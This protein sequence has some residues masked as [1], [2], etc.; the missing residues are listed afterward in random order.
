MVI[1]KLFSVDIFNNPQ[2]FNMY[3]CKPN[4]IPICQ[5]NGIDIEDASINIRLNNQYELSFK[6]FKYIDTYDG[7]IISNG[8]SSFDVGMEILVENIGYF[9]LEYPK[10]YLT[11][12]NE[13]KIISA[14]SID[15][16][17][18]NKDLINFKINLG[19][20][21]SLEYLVEYDENETEELINEYNGSPYDY[22][23]FYNTLDIQLQDI[24]NKYTDGVITDK[25]TI[26]KI[27]DICKI[28]P[29]LKN[30]IVKNKDN[31]NVDIINYVEYVYDSQK[32]ISSIILTD[33]NARI[34]ELI[35]F[36]GK[37]KKQLS[38]LDLALEKCNCN[39]KI[40]YVDEELCNKRFQFD[41]SG[42]N[43][44]S[45]LTQELASTVECLCMFDIKTRTINIVKPD[46]LG[47]DTGILL[48]RR[49]VLN[50]LDITLNENNLCTRYNVSGGNNLN[51]NYVNFGTSRIDDISYYLY[52]RD[53]E[54]NTRKYMSD[55][56]A[57]KYIEYS[58]DRELARDVFIDLSKQYNQNIDNIYDLNYR[59]P[60]DYL[61]NNWGSYNTKDLENLLKSFKSLLCT[62]I[63]MYKEEYSDLGCNDDGSVNEDYIKTT[64]Y[65]QDYFSY[66]NIISQ[67]TYAIDSY[68]NN[69]NYEDIQ[70]EATLKEIN[71]FKTEWSLYGIV[72]LQNKLETYKNTMKAMRDSK[73][74]YLKEDSDEPK[75]WSELNV[76]EKADF[77]NTEFNY[78]YKEYYDNYSAYVRCKTYL[79]E[80][81]VQLDNL[82]TQ[83]D[84]LQSKRKLISSYMDLN[85]YN[86][87]ELYNILYEYGKVTD[88]EIN[89]IVENITFTYE[90]IKTITML[91]IDRNYS[92]ENILTT[93]L[94]DSV[95]EIDKQKELLLDAKEKLSI[96]CQ[97][98]IDINGTFDNFLL[99][100]DFSKDSEQFEIGNYITIEYFDNYYIKLRLVG[101]SFNPCIP[102]NELSLE[103]SNYIMSKSKR[104]DLTYLLNN[105]S[106]GN[107]NNSSSNNSNNSNSFGVGDDIDV[108]ISNTMLSK[109]L[110]TEM[111]SSRV[112]NVILDTLDVNMLTAKSATFSDLYNGTTNIDGRCITTGY[113]V[114]KSYNG[115]DGSIN[116]TTGTIINLENG[117]FN[118]GGGSLKFDGT[119][120]DLTGTI[121]ATSGR[122]GTISNGLYFNISENGEL[123]TG[124]KSS[125]YSNVNGV[126]VGHNGICCGGGGYNSTNYQFRVDNYGQMSC[127]YASIS[128]GSISY[129]NI[130]YG[131]I[132][133]FSLNLTSLYS[134]NRT[135]LSSSNSGCYIGV[136]G[137]SY[138]GDTYTFSI[139]SSGDCWCDR[140]MSNEGIQIIAHNTSSGVNNNGNVVVGYG[141][142][143]NCNIY[144]GDY[145]RFIS[146]S[147]GQDFDNGV[148]I[149][150]GTDGT[151]YHLRPCGN[152]NSLGCIHLGTKNRR[153]AGVYA[154]NIY[155][156][157]D[158]TSISDIISSTVSS[159]VSSSINSAVSNA[160]S[161]CVKTNAGTTITSAQINMGYDKAADG[162]RYYFND[163]ATGR[164][165][166]L[167]YSSLEQISSVRY[168]ENIEYKGNDYWHDALMQVK[169]CT[170]N[171]I[172]GNDKSTKIGVI[173]EDLDNCMPELVVKN[174]YG[175]C[176]AV[177]YID[178][179][180]PLVSEVQR[181][182]KEID[183][184]KKIIQNYSE[185][186]LELQDSVNKLIN[187]D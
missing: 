97:P 30:K 57:N 4:G 176:E 49:N 130:S 45:F 151:T 94:D 19:T 145:I 1:I 165:N 40:G 117:K 178:F 174:E 69:S 137:I 13:Y 158:G 146:S 116:N 181:L 7:K 107:R 43:I 77:N 44:Y 124:S 148:R 152:S 153:W 23:M 89:N 63:T 11:E 83:Q 52:A 73:I 37:Y 186:V 142:T 80:L 185:T 76:G 54:Y 87:I 51:L 184:Y 126:Y 67:I 138:K 150:F 6:Y 179:I 72:E 159:S 141:N 164:F 34:S 48:S 12:D 47:K 109:L 144:F 131:K 8:Y 115:H 17:L 125:L 58:K 121:Y 118:F 71:A 133:S 10:T 127:S 166:A 50:T 134:G 88:Y 129:A 55:E 84:E 25:E 35:E 140:I 70:D 104:S 32:N 16:E 14:T 182:N 135:S 98:Q 114:D 139:D 110:N 154:D 62:L 175:E 75:T 92:N 136:D 81:L 5:L 168:K 108:T 187:K 82:N 171:Y 123:Y 105:A 74:I 36:Y 65:W 33:I 102:Q 38:L 95:T 160:T 119:S 66:N 147:T 93:L 56:L 183:E 90:D 101:F 111:F 132:G 68:S 20:K 85:N 143:N 177:T 24:L 91:Y 61:S 26:D 100:D 21:Q 29:R 162:N 39:W 172:N 53:N 167:R 161:N 46:R 128:Y 27:V 2:P 86:K 163:N 180:V 103:F 170:Y 96:D 59:V 113:I 42:Q 155:I 41:V 149:E 9:K 120:L 169:C 18:E 79:D 78:K 122:I 22:I 157:S 28:I 156:G 15:C 99:L 3:L 112:T 31:T 64:V 60:N 106:G 173:A